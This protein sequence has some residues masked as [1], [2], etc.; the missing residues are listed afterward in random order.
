MYP[1]YVHTYVS[2]LLKMSV[3]KVMSKLKDKSVLIIFDRH[4]GYQNKYGRY[5]WAKG[6]CAEMLGKTAEKVEKGIK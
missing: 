4:P 2:I 6:Y 5:L 1:N 3:S